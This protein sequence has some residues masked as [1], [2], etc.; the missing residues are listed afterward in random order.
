MKYRLFIGILLLTVNVLAQRPVMEDQNII[1]SKNQVIISDS[2]ECK[3]YS[4]SYG[5]DLNVKVDVCVDSIVK[6]KLLVVIV[7]DHNNNKIYNYL[8]DPKSG[9]ISISSH[10]ANGANGSSGFDG[11]NGLGGS[12]GFPNTESQ[13]VTDSDGNLSVTS[14]TVQ[15]RGGDGGDGSDGQNGGDGGNGYDGGNISISYSKLA[16]PYLSIIKAFSVGGI[17]G[18]GGSGGRGG[19]G[20]SAGQGE[21]AGN[22]GSDGRDGF[23]GSSGANGK[24]GKVVFIPI[25]SH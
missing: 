18:S 23:S 8:I 13:T 10:G 2:I 21:P 14:V 20:G 19:K 6:E 5:H 16:E 3:I 4:D 7:T 1:T 12:S 25:E 9:V 11:R 22:S 24:E 15:G 17:G